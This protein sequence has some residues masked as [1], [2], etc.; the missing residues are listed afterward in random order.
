MKYNFI[1][2][3]KSQLFT[4]LLVKIIIH[5]F[6]Y[7]DYSLE[8]LKNSLYI[9]PE[10]FSLLDKYPVEEVKKEKLISLIFKRK[11]IQEYSFNEHGKPLCK[12][13]YF[14]ISHSKG[15]I[16]FVEDV[17]P[18]GIDI[19]KILKSEMNLIAYVSSEQEREY[20]QNEKN[21]YEVWTNKEALV[22]AYGT[23]FIDRIKD[24]P[25]LPINS[26]RKY[27]G[28]TYHNQTIQIDDYVLTISRQAK[29]E[30][31][32]EMMKEEI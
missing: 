18:I 8:Q 11:Y 12:D 22:K 31:E 27:K 15:R 26:I 16:V 6:D 25:S 19:E 20:I 21:F 9:Y 7:K 17:V 29:E 2:T 5:Y 13:K 28:N 30:F 1:F 3:K 10:D 4:I 24:V 14:N 23:G 32:M